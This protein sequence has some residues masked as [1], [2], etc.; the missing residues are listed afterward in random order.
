M[1]CSV[2]RI[3]AWLDEELDAAER[4]AVERH[5]ETC[6]IC[7]E[8]A[9]RLREQKA[10][11]RREAAYYRAPAALREKIRG[12]LRRAEAPARH[13]NWRAWAL[14][15]SVLLTLSAAWNVFQT[16]PWQRAALADSVLD[17][18]L[19]SLAAGSLVDV[20]SSDQHTVKPWFAGKLDFSP[21]VKNLDE[22]GFPLAGGRIDYLGGQR[23]AAIVYRRRQHIIT[24]FTWP[25]ASGGGGSGKMERDGYNLLRWT[26][27]GMNY[28]AVSDV[29]P[30]EL[31]KLRDL[32]GQ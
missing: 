8:A 19:R 12:E 7:A 15:A 18:H 27:G 23:V 28:W 16:W 30:E 11:I 17:G 20:P 5:I 22:Q 25:S 2:D 31:E 1:N 4:A 13:T 24:L 9:S 3:E 32:Y 21:N 14:A 29:A 10:S 26:A 6:S